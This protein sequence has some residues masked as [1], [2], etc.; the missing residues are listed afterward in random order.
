MHLCIHSYISFS[1]DNF[2]DMFG[3][4]IV[5]DGESVGIELTASDPANKFNVVL[6]SASVPY[7]A[8]R[9][10][11]DARTSQTV[12]KRLSQTNL[13]SLFSS[14]KHGDTRVEY[15]RLVGPQGHAELAISK[16]KDL[17]C[18]YQPAYGGCDTPASEPA[19]DLLDQIWDSDNEFDDNHHPPAGPVG[20]KKTHQR[21]SS[22]P[23]S[24]LNDFMR[25]G[26]VERPSGGGPGG[27]NSTQGSTDNLLD[28][29]G[30]A[31]CEIYAGDLLDEFE[32]TK[33][34]PLWTMKGYTQIFHSWRESKRVQSVPLGQYV[35]YI[36]LPWWTILK[37]VLE[38]KNQP[39][40]TF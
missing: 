29:F 22:D 6:F 23:S 5:R 26:V 8:I 14:G 20:L 9:R 40:L 27:R 31:T 35:T 33:Y 36:T 28:T 15:V 25:L 34:N 37:D 7:E 39:L 30:D 11:Y 18:G 4:V 2:E 3:E 24:A 32:E 17:N 16:V 1:V 13:F 12:R 19:T 38:Q 21:R 10:V